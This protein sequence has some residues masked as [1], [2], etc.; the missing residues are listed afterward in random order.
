MRIFPSSSNK[1]AVGTINFKTQ[2]S[3]VYVEVQFYSNFINLYSIENVIKRGFFTKYGS[4]KS[5]NSDHNTYF[6]FCLKFIG[7]VT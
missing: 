3:T 6:L 2:K 4:G 1:T 7:L 5:Y